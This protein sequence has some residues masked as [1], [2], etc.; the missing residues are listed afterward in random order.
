MS[1]TALT[2][3]VPLPGFFG[4]LPSRGDFIGRQL[5]KTFVAPWDAWLQTAIAHSRAQMGEDTWREY[6]RVSPIWRFALGSGLCGADAY[7]GIMMPSMDRV[8]RYYPLAI[9]APLAPDG[10]LLALPSV[11]ET[12]FQQAEQLALAALERDD[13]DLEAFSHH[14][15]ALGA[16]MI[17]TLKAT[18][19]N[20]WYCPLPESLDLTRAAP[21]LAS[22]LLRRAF[23]QPSLWWTEGS[24][25][26]ARCLLICAG[27]PPAT[28]FAA[29]LSGE[30]RQLGWNE[31][32]FADA[33]DLAG[34]PM[35]AEET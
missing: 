35:T 11:S 8:G 20:A 9:A 17:P 34:G 21:T 18:G 6:Y 30:W 23:P 12:W 5:P 13:L 3:M 7:A 26:I 31:Q 29:L 33:A 25:W 2:A 28:G 32:S 10:P 15:A 24:E 14:V 1:G 16:P 27:L 4:K 22:H 19:G